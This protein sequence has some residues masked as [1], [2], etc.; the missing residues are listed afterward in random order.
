MTKRR[1]IGEYYN[2]LFVDRS[3]H[4]LIQLFRYIFV[5]GFSA[6]VDIGSLYIFTSH[7]H[8]HYLVSAFLAFIL[9]T[10]VNYFLSILWVFESSDKKKTE[11]LLFSLIGFGGL[12]LN[13]LILWVTVEQFHIFY[14]IGK[15]IS[16]AI[17]VFWSFSLRRLLFAKLAGGAMTQ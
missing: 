17:V 11:F 16:V 2:L 15:L 8:I 5:G 3:Q 10:I 14:L 9:G 13:G 12:L 7:L 4:G 6:L 1:T